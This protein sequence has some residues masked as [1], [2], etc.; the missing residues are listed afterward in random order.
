MK[1]DYP[2]EII[3]RCLNTGCNEVLFAYNQT[4]PYSRA[5]K[6]YKQLTIKKDE[7]GM[8]LECPKC[9][10]KHTVLTDKNPQDA[11]G[12]WSVGG[13]RED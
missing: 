5:V 11:N 10:S 3:Q 8:Y 13:L 12:L 7:K 1:K 6:V 4:S 9:G 2:R